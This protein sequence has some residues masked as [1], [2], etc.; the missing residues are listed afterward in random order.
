MIAWQS[1][2]MDFTPLMIDMHQS[3]DE[4]N[5]GSLHASDKEIAG[6]EKNIF[7]RLVSITRLQIYLQTV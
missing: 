4:I 5:L 6:R 3:S 2:S 1:V 7:R